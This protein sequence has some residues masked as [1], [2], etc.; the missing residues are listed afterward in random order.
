MSKTGIPILRSMFIHAQLLNRT[1]PFYGYA[2]SDILFDL[3]LVSTLEA[4]K[5]DIARFKQLLVIGRRVNYNFEYK[6]E[7]DN[8]TSISQY[9]RNGQMFQTNAL[10]YF[11]T[12]HSGYPWRTIPNFVVGRVGYDNWLVA[13]ALQKNISV[14]DATLTLSALHQTGLDGNFAGHTYKES[15]ERNVNLRL[16]GYYFDYSTGV[17]TC[18][19]FITRR[20][21]SQVLILER[22]KEMRIAYK[23]VPG[24]TA[25][26]AMLKLIRQQMI[27]SNIARIHMATKTFKNRQ[28]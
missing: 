26:E 4:L 21:Q 2:N 11:I 27:M 1:T 28:S 25:P 9:V 14:V 17:T 3:N 6:Q 20:V 23:C 12:K 7:I 13:T 8:L 19:H 22:P 16:A 24:V 18:S 10:D 5:N 15:G